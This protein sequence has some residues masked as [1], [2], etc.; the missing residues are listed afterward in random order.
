MKRIFY[1]FFILFFFISFFSIFFIISLNRYISNKYIISLSNQKIIELIEE[2]NIKTKN[3][4]RNIKNLGVYIKVLE[5]D[6]IKSKSDKITYDFLKLV[7]SENNIKELKKNEPYY[8][9]VDHKNE[10]FFLILNRV[11]DENYLLVLTTLTSLQ[12]YVIL[13]KI[14]V[15]LVILFFVIFSLILAKYIAKIIYKPNKKKVLSGIVHDLKTPVAVI[16]GYIEAI[17]EGVIEENEIERYYAT[18]EDQIYKLDRMINELLYY[19]KLEKDLT[20]TDISEFDI[21][22]FLEEIL[23]KFYLDIKNVNFI[24]EIESKNIVSNKK[25]LSLVIGNILTNAFA[26]CDERKIIKIK[27][28]ENILMVENTKDKNSDKYKKYG[29]TGLGLEIVYDLLKLLRLKHDFFN[30]DD[31]KTTIFRIYF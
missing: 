5:I 1:K 18:I 4:K 30:D 6:D 21:K 31:S 29:G 26:H 2:N 3:F 12:E 13:K 10:K 11:N 8:R 16:N 17:K 22:I 23:E 20:K 7:F 14:L 25:I 28:K 9:I 24:F 27:F 19:S 15:L